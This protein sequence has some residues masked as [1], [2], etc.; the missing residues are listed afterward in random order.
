MIENIQ[1]RRKCSL[2]TTSACCESSPSIPWKRRGKDF[3]YANSWCGDWQER[4]WITWSIRVTDGH[5]K[6][7][8]K[9]PITAQELLDEQANEVYCRWA[10][11]RVGFPGSTYNWIRTYSW[12]RQRA[13]KEQNRKS[14]LPHYWYACCISHITRTLAGHQEWDEFIIKSERRNN[15]CLLQITCIRLKLLQWV[16][17]TGHLKCTFAHYN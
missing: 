9:Q 2:K 3:V 11:S 4:Y 12:R 15:E 14:F 17:V 1:G 6:Q 8:R 5:R 10:S 7:W 16:S 13:L